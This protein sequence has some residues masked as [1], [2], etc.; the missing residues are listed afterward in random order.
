MPTLYEYNK[1]SSSKYIV[2]IVLV[3]FAV[4]GPF[5]FFQRINQFFAS[6]GVAYQLP[7]DPTQNWIIG[8]VVALLIGLGW[9]YLF[10]KGGPGSYRPVRAGGGGRR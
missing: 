9:L 8:A 10:G 5:I 3:L 1:P 2:G 6:M 7:T 4:L